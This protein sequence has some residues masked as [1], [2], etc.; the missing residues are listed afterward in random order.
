MTDAALSSDTQDIV[1]QEVFPHAPGTI[2]K[3]LTTGE[4]M[5]RWLHMAPTGFKPVKGTRFTYQTTPAG[6][7]DGT[8]LCQVLASP[9]PSA[10]S[11]PRRAVTRRNVGYGSLLDTVATFTLTK[12]QTG[13]RL[14]VVHSGFVIPKNDFAFN[15]MSGGWKKVVGNVGVIA[16]E[17]H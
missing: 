1:V 17:Q 2:W 9:G 14:R 16:A 11:M 4:L 6:E 3:T 15:N 8:I 13:T 10:S 12:V 5:A 7:W